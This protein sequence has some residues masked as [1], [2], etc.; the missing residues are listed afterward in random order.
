MNTRMNALIL[1][2]FLLLTA[3]Q[4]PAADVSALPYQVVDEGGAHGDC[5]VCV[6]P[7]PAGSCA[8]GGQVGEVHWKLPISEELNR[9]KVQVKRLDGS[10]LE[11]AA[12]GHEGHAVLPQAVRPDD[13]VIVVDEV[14]AKELFYIRVRE[15]LGCTLRNHPA[16]AI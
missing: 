15:P 13:K 12:G 16:A 2:G 10:R 8:D 14:S 5:R 6:V 11:V 4:R 1:G 7:A 9:I 3:C